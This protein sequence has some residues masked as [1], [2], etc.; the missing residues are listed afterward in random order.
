MS[1]VG[2]ENDTA[3]DVFERH[4]KQLEIFLTSAMNRKIQFKLAKSKLAW[5][6]IPM[7]GFIVGEGK[8]TVQPG[9]AQALKD[10]PDPKCIEDVTSFRAFANFLREFLPRFQELDQRLKTCTKKGAKWDTWIADPEN[11]KAFRAMRNA[12]AETAA[13]YM[14]DYHAAQD[15]ASGRPLEL[16]VD[17]CEYG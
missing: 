5:G 11:M 14:P 15:N 12:L 13:L 2:Y 8:R 6:R 9:K 10:W 1:T 7:L 3:E 4:V 17:A 16:Y